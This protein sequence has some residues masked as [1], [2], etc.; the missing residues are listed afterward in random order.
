MM[1]VR[2]VRRQCG[3]RKCKNVDS[4]AI[5]RTRE[6]GNSIIICRDC[7]SEAL[8]IIDRMGD[9]KTASSEDFPIPITESLNDIE[10][11]EDTETVSIDE[12]SEA[13]EHNN[14]TE[15]IC[16]KCGRVFASEAGLK[17]H[18]CKE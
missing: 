8:D 18:K 10:Q 16:D 2:K 7:L 6:A 3:V 13:V 12:N 15:F 4:Y 5:S 9:R 17:R 1:T 14:K 11:L